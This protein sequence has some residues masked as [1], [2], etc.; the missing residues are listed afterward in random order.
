MIEERK[1]RDILTLFNYQYEPFNMIYIIFIKNFYAPSN[2]NNFLSIR[3]IVQ[4]IKFDL[5]C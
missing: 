2:R 1:Q 3:K 4:D 5:Q